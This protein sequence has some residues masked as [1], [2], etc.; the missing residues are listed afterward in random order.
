M[1]GLR[2][3]LTLYD[4]HTATN[5]PVNING[6]NGSIQGHHRKVG[7]FNATSGARLIQSH[8]RSMNRKSYDLATNDHYDSTNTAVDRGNLH[9]DKNTEINAC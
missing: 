9:T 8:R 2:D 3:K 1:I 7:S 5:S 6:G 4:F